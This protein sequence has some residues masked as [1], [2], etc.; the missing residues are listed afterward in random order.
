MAPLLESLKAESPSIGKM[1]PILVDD[2]SSD[3]TVEIARRFEKEL[4]LR[5]IKHEHNKGLG[6][7]I[8][9]GLST[10]ISEAKD[11]DIIVMLDTDNSHN[12]NHIPGMIKLL[13]KGNDIVIAS[14]YARGGKEVGLV[15]WRSLGSKIISLML[16]CVFNVR[17]V[18]D[19]TSGYRAYTGAIIRKGFAVYG[20][21]LVSETS[22]VCMAELLV[23]LCSVGA[24]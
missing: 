23:K 24:K 22:F 8:L 9:T 7:A 12:P 3:N 16:T 19:Y 11:T 20:N 6:A 21:N 1:M 10:V 2:G 4:G 17:G 5:V 18:R 13:E 15:Y 14:R